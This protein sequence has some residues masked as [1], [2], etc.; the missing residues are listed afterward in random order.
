MP[1]RALDS[2]EGQRVELNKAASIIRSGGVVAFPTESFYGLGVSARDEKA[3]Q[4]LFAIKKREKNQPILLLIPTAMLLNQYVIR[5]VRWWGTNSG[6]FRGTE[7]TGKKVDIRI[8]YFFK[9]KDGRIDRITEYYDLAT[10]LAQQ[11]QLVGQDA[12]LG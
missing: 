6:V 2:G 3:I 9:L 5:Q 8:A 10:I 1:P 11:G 4:R 7:P 12:G